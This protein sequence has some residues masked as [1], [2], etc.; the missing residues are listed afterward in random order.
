[1]KE[2]KRWGDRRDGR[3]IRDLDGVHAIFP[4]LMPNRTDAE[5]YI[6]EDIDVT[7]LMRYLKK[8]NGPDVD[9]KTTA[10]HAF[11]AA[12]AK[13]V[14]HRPLLNRFVAGKRM[15]QRE[16]IT[17]SFVVK[18]KFQ[19]ESEEML[20]TMPVGADTALSDISHKIL[21]D[22]KELRQE[23]GSNDMDKMLNT[24]ARLP[25]F[26]LRAIMAFL[27]FLDFHGWVPAAISD[28]DTN[29]S[30]VLLSNLGSIKCNATYHHLN[31]YGTNSI[32][33][34]I[35]EIHK[36]QIINAD[37]QAEIRDIASLGVTLDERIADGFYFAKSVTLL[38]AILA[39][40]KSL[41]APIKERISYDD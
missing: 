4:Y 6:N 23:K 40:P 5:V 17:M 26:L 22:T 13:T 3:R 9:F 14:Y 19:D 2:S 29:Y 10:F 21:G 16:E 28:G 12:I 31:N 41:E 15:Y 37:G 8:K 27:R 35:G 25:R 32:I 34:T 11:V 38:K 1:M 30:T 7:A 20:M 24:L 33:I 36:A 18:R 39:D